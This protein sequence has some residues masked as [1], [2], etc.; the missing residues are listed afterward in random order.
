MRK[1][2]CKKY[3]HIFIHAFLE[4]EKKK[5]RVGGKLGWN[6]H[7]NFFLHKYIQESVN[8]KYL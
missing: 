3:I 6:T 7:E 1:K 5:C 2:K 8:S 4:M